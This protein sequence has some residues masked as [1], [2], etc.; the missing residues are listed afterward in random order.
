MLWLLTLERLSDSG[1]FR[2]C[3]CKSA[4]GLLTLLTQLCSPIDSLPPVT[5]LAIYSSTSRGSVLT[6]QRKPC[7][8][9]QSKVER[10]GNIK[11]VLEL[12]PELSPQGW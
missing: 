11:E 5:T 4:G 3:I 8:Q 12:K 1:R 6:V 9:A 2:V 7:R 10:E